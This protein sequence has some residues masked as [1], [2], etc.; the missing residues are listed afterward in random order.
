MTSTNAVQSNRANA[1]QLNTARASAPNPNAILSGYKP[2]GASERTARQDGLHAGVG[3]SHRM[4]QTDLGKLKKYEAAFEAAGK[5]HGVP[6]ALLAAIASRESRGGSALDRSGHGDGGNGFGLM[7]VDH[8]Y[9]SAKG[10]PYSAQHIDQAAGILKGMLNQVKKNHPDWPAAQQLRGAVAAYNSGVS[11]VQTIKNMDVGTTGN[12]YSNDV[13]ARAQKL[14]PHFGGTGGASGPKPSNE[15]KFPK[16]DGQ[17]TAAP[18]LG[19]VA[20]GEERLRIGHKGESVKDLQKLL[21]FP[22]G[23]RDG[24][25]GPDTREAVHAFQK[26]NGMKATPGTEGTVGPTTLK[27][28][29]NGGRPEETDKPA[30]K[31]TGPK[32]SY[33]PGDKKWTQAPSLA[34]V[35]EGKA[36]LRE[37]MQGG[38]VKHVQKLLGVDTDGKYGPATKK[39]VAQFQ[40][41]A[42][43]NPPDGSEGHVGKTTLAKLEKAAASNGVDG[44]SARGRAQMKELM[45]IAQRHSAGKRPDG[46][47][48]KHVGDYLDR[49]SYGKIGHGKAPRF[50]LARNMGDYLNKNHQSLGLKKLNLDNPYK[51]P[52]GAI[53]V[54]RPGTP[55]TRHPTAGDIVVKGPGSHFYNGGEMGYGGPQNFPRGN[56]HVI[57]IFV[58]Q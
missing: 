7:Q 47:C 56:R 5:K 1:A 50:P 54:V 29:K 37:G 27:W 23:K 24:F 38:A 53:I 25:Y 6:P 15:V 42:G 39:A 34:D 57:G 46:Y 12:D 14:A 58:P 19:D 17:Y 43:L 2:T 10:G 31:P 35:K 8:R 20:K 33:E 3:A 40:K 41:A 28:L 13:W 32:D 4:A 18:S 45:N 16:F 21:G 22:E 49:T 55:G 11:N 30:P 51:A 26:K 52:P 36:T 44:I 48:L 9:H